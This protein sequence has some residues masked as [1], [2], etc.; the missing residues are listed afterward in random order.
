MELSLLLTGLFQ[1]GVALNKPQLFGQVI[2]SL[3]TQPLLQTSTPTLTASSVLG[4]QEIFASVQQILNENV[5]R[6]SDISQGQVNDSINQALN[7]ADTTGQTIGNDYSNSLIQD[8]I[9]S[10]D[11]IASQNLLNEIIQSE[12]NGRNI[13]NESVQGRDLSQ[14]V[15]SN[16]LVSGI[17]AKQP[18]ITFRELR[19]ELTKQ[20]KTQGASSVEA[21]K[22]A[23]T[24]V[25]GNLTPTIPATQG[26]IANELQIT[27][28]NIAA[29][30][31][32]SPVQSDTL[33]T[34][35]KNTVA[36]L[37]TQI[38]DHLTTLSKFNNNKLNEGV[39]QTIDQFLAPTLNLYVFA[40]KL[41]DPGNTFLYSAQTGLMYAH[42][43]PSNY[44]KG[45]DIVV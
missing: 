36:T 8:G 25:T 33:T 17:I 6:Q 3:P 45:V 9:N 12:I 38:D 1:L 18:D 22:A 27:G 32:L 19:D 35:L 2:S 15:L 13:L 16:Q 23:S 20:F 41:R 43:Q 21:F 31:G 40:E 11:A 14:S 37:R 26:S 10:N 39:K 44:I 5:A 30:L 28:K 29:N 4:D 7:N 24:L 42:P 34:D